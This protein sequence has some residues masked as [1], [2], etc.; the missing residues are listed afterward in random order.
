MEK[1]NFV[2]LQTIF[3][4]HFSF[5]LLQEKVRGKNKLQPIL[6]GVCKESVM[7][8][9][10]KTKRVSNNNYNQFYLVFSNERL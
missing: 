9:D 3:I 7:R 2:I 1:C 10:E 5:H 4:F 8:V 6:F